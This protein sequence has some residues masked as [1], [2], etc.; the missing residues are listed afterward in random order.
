M[1]NEEF[2]PTLPHCF[3]IHSKCS[4]TTEP[5]RLGFNQSQL[6]SIC[7]CLNLSYQNH[8]TNYCVSHFGHLSSSGKCLQTILHKFGHTICPKQIN[9]KN[10]FSHIYANSCKI[11]PKCR[12]KLTVTLLQIFWILWEGVPCVIRAVH[13]S[14]L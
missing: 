3:Q 5:F 7:W 4:L 13:S 14:H 2:E 11:W 12:L 8:V 1:T 10:I 6:Y 9:C